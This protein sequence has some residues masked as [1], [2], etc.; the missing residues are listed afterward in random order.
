M[1][2]VTVAA[3]E[4][5]EVLIGEG[6]SDAVGGLCAAV[7]PN[8]TVAVVSD[9][10]VFPLY[11][12]RVCQ[13]LQTSGF[14]VETFVFP[15][16]EQQKNLT[17]YGDLLHF[18]CEKELT[19]TDTLLALGGGVVGDLTGFA[20]ATYLRGIP[21][22]GVPTS[23]LAM[24]DSSV[25]GKT[26]VDLDIGKNQ[27]GCFYQPRRVICDP[28]TLGT[29]PD[30]QWACGSAEVIK[31]GL[32]GNEPFFR[33]LDEKP[34]E[35]W[36]EEVIATCVSMKRDIVEQDEF[37]HGC[38]KLLNL[39]HSVGHAVET[40]SHYQILHGQAVAIGMAVITRAAVQKGICEPTVLE[41]TERLLQ[42]YGLPVATDFSAEE[43]VKIMCNDKKRQGDWMQ[44]VVPE[45]IGVCRVEKVPIGD[46]A[47]WLYAGG[48][49]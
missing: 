41:E 48:I 45:Q 35:S 21:F 5:Y 42:Q 23:L 15:A 14:R 46:L 20:A 27:V 43:L 2:T 25:G 19:R 4:Q 37:E 26:A 24:V 36:M 17:T 30:E 3:S 8:G 12:E 1:K 40:A 29:L 18:L 7:V 13:S 22:I 47:E 38:R 49:R 44:L 33:A 32:L 31:Y 11:G 16:G 39:G 6:L 10:N 34:M 28:L 9:S